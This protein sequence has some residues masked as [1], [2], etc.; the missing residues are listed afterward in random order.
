[1]P[2]EIRWSNAVL[3]VPALIVAG[4]LYPLWHNARWSAGLWPLAIATGWAQVLALWDFS[5]G[6]VMSWQPTRGPK[7]ASR[8]FRKAV[9]IWNGSLA[10]VWLA[11]AAWRTEQAFSLRFA[12]V[13]AFG[14]VNAVVIWRVVF[15]G[16]EAR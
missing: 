14:A 7:D 10:V 11:M 12:V 3:L 2:G 8:R 16:K 5:R 15:P 4:V 9:L 1:L 6:R 13:A